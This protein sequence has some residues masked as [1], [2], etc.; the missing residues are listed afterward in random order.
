[1]TP[2]TSYPKI[3]SVTP[4]EGYQL[5]V[6]FRNDVTKI[7]DCSGVLNEPAFSALRNRAIFCAVQVDQGGYGVF[8]TDD[9]DLSESELWLHGERIPDDQ[10]S[11]I[12][13]ST[14]TYEEHSFTMIQERE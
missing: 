12:H 14:N 7:Y 13:E 2:M 11:S 10:E 4:L 1:M 8:W 9:I 3:L 5:Q 6:T